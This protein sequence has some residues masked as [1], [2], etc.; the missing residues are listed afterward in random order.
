[1]ESVS[2]DE[3]LKVNIRQK[4][5]YNQTS[6]RKNFITA[7]WSY[8]RNRMISDFRESSGIKDRVY[9]QHKAWMGDLSGKK[10]LDLGCLRGNALSIYLAK[11]ASRYVGIDLSDVAIEKLKRKL[12][13]NNCTNA[14]ALAV[15]FYSDDFN[16]RDFDIIYAYGVIHH[17]P[18]LNQLFSRINEVLKPGGIIVSYDP[19]QTSTPVKIVRGL[20]R[21]FQ[22]DKD[23]EWP[24]D[25][26]A[27]NK[28]KDSFVIKEMHGILG[29]SKWGMVLN[30]LPWPNKKEKIAKMIEKDWNVKKFNSDLWSCMQV[31][32]LLQRK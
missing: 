8:I 25:K 15:D 17:F 10:V 29:S 4:E 11:N 27:L 7:G 2:K 22:S 31:T 14:S 21:P 26:K 30:F 18:D 23:W 3:T 20:Y 13:K 6:E 12:E 19:L 28:I 32:F 9:E 5:F 1:M 16:E 24:F